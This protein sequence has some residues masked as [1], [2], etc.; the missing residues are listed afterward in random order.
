[1]DLKKIISQ[2][3]SESLEFKESLKL[4][5]CFL[6][7]FLILIGELVNRAI[8]K[9]INWSIE[10]DWQFGRLFSFLFLNWQIG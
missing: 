10:S 1:M 9:L 5:D 8:G 6:I 3:E 4:I 2:D 7:L